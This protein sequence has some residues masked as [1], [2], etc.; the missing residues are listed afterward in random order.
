MDNQIKAALLDLLAAKDAEI[1]RLTAERDA[2][3]KDMQVMALEMRESEEMP[4]GCCFAC[5]YDSQ[6][7]PDNVILAYG[8]CPGYDRDDCFAWRGAG[9]GR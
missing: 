4:E 1:E 6:N 9:E 2:A 7:L 8:E 3:I 5:Q